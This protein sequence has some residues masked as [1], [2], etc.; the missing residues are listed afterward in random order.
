MSNSNLRMIVNEARDIDRL[1]GR[2]NEEN[3][4]VDCDDC[5]D[6]A[7]KLND[8]LGST[9]PDHEISTD[10]LKPIFEKRFAIS[11][12]DLSKLERDIV[13]LAIIRELIMRHNLVIT[14]TDFSN[15]TS[16]VRSYRN[17]IYA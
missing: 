17:A 9:A 7:R 11:E 10:R 2:C 16:F 5:D 14:R 15:W 13:P 3:L 8:F 6:F 12:T 1:A 4:T